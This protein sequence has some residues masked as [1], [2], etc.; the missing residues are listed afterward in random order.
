MIHAGLDLARRLEAFEALTGVACAEAHQRLNPGLGAAAMEVA[1]GF[2]IFVGAESPLTHAVGLGMRGEVGAGEMDRME[3]FYRARGAAVS[4][5]LCPLAGAWLVELLGARGYRVTEFNN[6]LVRPLAGPEAQADPRVRLASAD[7]EYLW[8]RTVGRGFL[9]KD[10]LTAEEMDV[11]RAIWHMPGSRCYLAFG[12]GQ[13][14]A[15]GAMALHSGLAALFA[16]STLRGFRGAGLQS[17]LIRERL[18]VAGEEG[19]D[20]AMAATLPGSISQRNYERNGFQ[21]VYTRTTL[22]R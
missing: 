5:E 2:A 8:T 15:A 9:E 21:V 19:C 17:A 10:D 1:G 14:A 3:T 7:D 20:L 18:R 11:G 6:V 22:V 16:D 4:L 13:A 12:G